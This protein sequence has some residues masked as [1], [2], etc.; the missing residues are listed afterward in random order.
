VLS[1]D[2]NGV[3]PEHVA[4]R[5]LAEA[6]INALGGVDLIMATHAL[7]LAL[8]GL[9]ASDDQ[10]SRRDINR[11]AKEVAQNI[12][13]VAHSF[14]KSAALAPDFRKGERGAWH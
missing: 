2:E 5:K 11:L 12:A 8:G 7:I 1:P 9:V 13:A 3:S 14:R 4:E 10:L 6:V